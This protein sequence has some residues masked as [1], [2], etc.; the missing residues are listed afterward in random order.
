MGTQHFFYCASRLHTCLVG[1]GGIVFFRNERG[2]MA[3][4]SQANAAILITD[5]HDSVLQ[6]LHGDTPCIV[7][8]TCHGYDVAQPGHPVLLGFNGEFKH[9]GTGSYLLGNGYRPYV[10]S[11]RRFICPDSYSPFGEGDFN[12]YA[13]CGGDPVNWTDPSGHMFRRPNSPAA[14]APVSVLVLTRSRSPSPQPMQ[15]A[16]RAHAPSPE[17]APRPRNPVG[18]RLALGREPPGLP[19]S[20]SSSPSSS[21]SLLGGRSLFRSR[22]RSSSSSSS[23]SSY[24]SELDHSRSE[25]PSNSSISSLP[26]LATPPLDNGGNS[27]RSHSADQIHVPH[28]NPLRSDVQDV[29]EGSASR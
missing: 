2:L 21:D 16:N 12:A 3:E 27:S 25:S 19:R 22:S 17:V 6:R 23:L 14:P 9:S 13:F 4:L 7:A 8:Y 15:R 29:R 26:P 24:Y 11:L 5:H 20:N 28:H 1:G 18:R 10:P